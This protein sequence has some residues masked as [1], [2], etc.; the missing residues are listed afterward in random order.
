MNDLF[1]ISKLSSNQD[2]CV[3]CP[4]YGTP[5]HKKSSQTFRRKEMIL[6]AY[7]QEEV[8]NIQMMNIITTTSNADKD[9]LCRP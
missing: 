1:I 8:V 9:K 4:S 7:C 3:V 6:K 2:A 5:H